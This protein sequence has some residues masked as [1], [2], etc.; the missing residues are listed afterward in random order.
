MFTGKME[1]KWQKEIYLNL[2]II[3]DGTLHA[4]KYIRQNRKRGNLNLS[5]NWNNCQLKY[6]PERFFQRLT[7]LCTPFIFQ[8]KDTSSGSN[9]GNKGSC[10]SKFTGNRLHCAYCAINWS[11]ST[12]ATTA[13]TMGTAA[14]TVKTKI[15]DIFSFTDRN[16][17]KQKELKF[18]D[19]GKSETIYTSLLLSSI[20]LDVLMNT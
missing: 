3:Q 7:E 12:K 16:A 9:V 13:S 11:T 19:V 2:T 17:G 6:K 5:S 15:S 4:K 10:K 18:R 8:K 20:R 1:R 14:R